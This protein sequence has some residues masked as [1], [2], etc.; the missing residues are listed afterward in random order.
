MTWIRLDIFKSVLFLFKDSLLLCV[1]Y[2]HFSFPKRAFRFENHCAVENKSFQM[3][4]QMNKSDA[5]FLQRY[6]NKM[7]KKIIIYKRR[8]HY[9]T[10]RKKKVFC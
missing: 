10:H 4:P 2:F 1:F 7:E 3:I 6:T 9:I 8:L 5:N